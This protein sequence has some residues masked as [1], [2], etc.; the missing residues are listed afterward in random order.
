[1]PL[2]PMEELV[3]RAK[4]LTG[5][6]DPVVTE[7]RIVGVIEWRDGTVLDVVRQLTPRK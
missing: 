3:D 1:M 7:E 6:M 4:K 5:P 2:V